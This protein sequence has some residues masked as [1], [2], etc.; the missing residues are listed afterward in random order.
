MCLQTGNNDGQQ[1]LLRSTETESAVS[2]AKNRYSIFST[3]VR[4]EEQVSLSIAT[5]TESQEGHS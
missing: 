2:T 4:Q 3:E 1:S 5:K